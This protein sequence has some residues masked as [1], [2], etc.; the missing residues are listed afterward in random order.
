[1]EVMDIVSPYNAVGFKN[2]DK[3]PG[4]LTVSHSVN[5]VHEDSRINMNQSSFCEWDSNVNDII[6]NII[7]MGYLIYKV[8]P[9]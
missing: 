2:I 6:L 7:R 1:M 3:F 5:Y 9:C 8:T 4:E